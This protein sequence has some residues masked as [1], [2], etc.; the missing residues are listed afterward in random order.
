MQSKEGTIKR[1]VQ[2][3]SRSSAAAVTVVW[4]FW[5]KHQGLY[6]ATDPLPQ[7]SQCPSSRMHILD[8]QCCL[9]LP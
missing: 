5:H 7:L 1:G 4:V 9:F 8:V 3:S 6:E 2:L